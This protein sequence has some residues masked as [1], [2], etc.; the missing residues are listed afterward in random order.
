[1]KKYKNLTI[2]GSSHIAI[3]S[4][5]EVKQILGDLK[6][7]IIALE[8]DQLRLAALISNE[9]KGI[10]LKDIKEIGFKGFLFNLIGGWIEK[11]LGKMVGVSPG[12]EMK[13]AFK[14]ARKNKMRV[15][16]IDQDIRITLKKLSK[17]ITWKEKW[18]FLVDLIKGFVFRKVEITIDL[19]KVP[20]EEL[21]N[22]VIKKVKKRYPSFY[23]VL[24]KERNVIMGK[25]LYKIMSENKDKQIV[26]IVGAGHGDGLLKEIKK[27]EV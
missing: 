7:E 12:E 10:S 14:I 17:A 16:L 21:I 20:E 4:V 27:N 13:T 1:M 25:V 6:P 9:K 23:N 22:M 24:I 5:N 8:L 18:R 2:I 11:K 3:Q 26:A 19:S 15:F